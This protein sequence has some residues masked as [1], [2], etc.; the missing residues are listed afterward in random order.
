MNLLRRAGLEKILTREKTEEENK[1]GKKKKK[2][3][4]Y[5]DSD[6]QS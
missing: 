3:V 1:R 5:D 2:R 6:S 4:N